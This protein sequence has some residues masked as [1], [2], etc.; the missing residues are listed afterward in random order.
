MLGD[1]GNESLKEI[2][3]GGR[4][5]AL[6]REFLSGE[7][8]TCR[9]RMNQ[10]SCHRLFDRFAGETNCSEV[11]QEPPRRLDVRLNG[12]CN[13]QCIMCDVWRQPNKVYDATSFWDEGPAEIFP[14]LKEI[15]LLGGEPFIQ[16]DTFRLIEAVS[17]V[18]P[19]CLWAFVTNGQVRF[20]R[21]IRLALDRIRIREFQVSIDSLDA[22][23]YRTIRRQGDLAQ[24]LS[25]LDELLGLGRDFPVKASMCVLQTNWRE[26]PAFLEF[27]TGR[28]VTPE[29][30]FAYYD[31]GSGMSLERLSKVDKAE[32]VRFLL[33]SVSVSDQVR[34]APVLVPLVLAT[35]Q[36]VRIGAAGDP[37][38][39]G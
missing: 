34:L 31:A 5:Q 10:I 17:A 32:V 15:D 38:P 11:M 30:Q 2:W 21:R 29:L 4:M 13:L 37:A 22:E 8:R 36:R 39:A 18:N 7:V 14:F 23:T 3:N 20:S 26:V 25:F 27:C 24:T 9:S 35:G 33:Q 6:R 28:G 12:R 16:Q 19:S 1:A